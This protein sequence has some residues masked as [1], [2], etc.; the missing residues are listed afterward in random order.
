MQVGCVG[1]VGE[2]AGG[3]PV[4]DNSP[5]HEIAVSNVKLSGAVRCSVSAVNLPDGDG[6]ERRHDLNVTIIVGGRFRDGRMLKREGGDLVGVVGGDR[7]ARGGLG[8]GRH[9]LFAPEEPA[10]GG[11]FAVTRIAILRRRLV[12]LVREDRQRLNPIVEEQ[13]R[14]APMRGD[15]VVDH[16]GITHRHS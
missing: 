5:I 11:G 1:R 13:V 15:A 2:K 14:G 3:N 6:R 10:R 12:P 7:A 4:T 16:R 8:V 9:D